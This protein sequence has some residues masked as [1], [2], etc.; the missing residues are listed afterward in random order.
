MSSFYGKGK[1]VAFKHFMNPASGLTDL[2][3]LGCDL[4]LPIENT[5]V[6][7]AMKFACLLYNVKSIDRLNGARTLLAGKGK[8][9]K[10][11]PPTEAT[12][13][14]HLLRTS[15]Q[16]YVW[17]QA[18]MNSPNLP[19]PKQFGFEQNG[20]DIQAK[21]NPANTPI[22]APELLNQLVCDCEDHCDDASCCCVVNEQ[23]CTEACGCTDSQR[24]Y[25]CHNGWVD[26]D[27][28]VEVN[29]E[30]N[31]SESDEEYET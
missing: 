5:I 3:K 24:T 30:D 7:T 23:P 9:G 6:D 2:K 31:E 26:N 17:R 16:V 29:G 28:D 21:M 27:D 11:L 22:S 1:T 8:S 15:Y 14:L 10:F 12:F 13:G 4:R 18:H 19:D 20:D 25:N